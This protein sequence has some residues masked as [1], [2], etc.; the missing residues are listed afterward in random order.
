M[1]VSKIRPKHGARHW[2]GTGLAHLEAMIGGEQTQFG[3]SDIPG[4]LECVLIPQL[5]N[6]R[7]FD[8]DVNGLPRLLEIEKSCQNLAAFAKAKPENQ[9]D[10]PD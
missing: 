9:P 6:A 10:A 5:Y 2:I 8:V 3:L 4:A 7:R 1:G